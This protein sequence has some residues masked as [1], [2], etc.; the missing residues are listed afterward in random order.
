MADWLQALSDSMLGCSWSTV[1]VSASSVG[2]AASPGPGAPLC[3]LLGL[4]PLCSLLALG[5][6]AVA[7]WCRCRTVTCRRAVLEVPASAVTAC[8]VAVPTF[9]VAA[10][11]D[12]LGVLRMRR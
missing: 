8:A 4:A 9:A 7:R 5:P 10:V 1:S 12:V 3:P 11:M 2:T 6:L